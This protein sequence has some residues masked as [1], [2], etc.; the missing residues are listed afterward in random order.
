MLKFSVPAA[1]FLAALLS[2]GWWLWEQ[3]AAKPASTLAQGAPQQLKDI[4]FDG[5]R[6][7]GYLKQLCDIG[8]RPSGSPGMA[9]QQAL[10]T[11]HFEQLGAKV[12]RQEF[13][14]H[15]RG[16]R[17]LVDLA[18]LIVQWRPELK[19]RVLL[20]AHYDTRPFPDRDP[21][22]EYRKG[23]FV[24]ANDGAS[25]VALL[26]ELAHDMGDLQGN[27][28]V[29]FVLF[30][31]EE[32]VF[33]DKDKYFLGSEYFSL[34]YK[35]SRDGARY[36]AGVLLDMVGDADLRI[37]MEKNSLK[38]ARD[39]THDIF[40]TAERLGVSEFVRRPKHDLRD[41]HIPLNT[42]AKIRTC[43]IIDFDY[44]Y[45]HTTGD[46]PSR[47]SALSLAKVGWVV[48]EWLKSEL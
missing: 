45:W 17:K 1:L 29:D 20:C 48:R 38:Y 15:H 26:M 27:V 37:Y 24:G 40:R 42:I 22:N 33:S 31:G 43:D 23:V 6:A 30:D 9:K 3:L 34:Q 25:G 35:Q 11:Q 18:N 47:C 39:V 4:P 2:G 44:S 12:V 13:R 10:L 14:Y 16:Q 7:Y 28:G 19:Q 5:D 8:P 21:I 32:F 36:R 46:I 41:D